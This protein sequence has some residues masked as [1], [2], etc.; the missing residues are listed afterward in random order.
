MLHKSW[1]TM[2]RFRVT[3]QFGN[4]ERC[5]NV[6]QSLLKIWYIGVSKTRKKQSGKKFETHRRKYRNKNPSVR[7][8][9]SVY[10]SRRAANYKPV[11]IRKRSIAITYFASSTIG[12][13]HAYKEK[14]NIPGCSIISSRL[15]R[16][17]ILQFRLGPWNKNSLE[18]SEG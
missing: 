11:R 18:Q 5:V 14:I 10:R 3:M 8:K 4:N 6:C 9:S 1:E 15:P 2:D 17:E 7:E 13:L 12:R 16:E